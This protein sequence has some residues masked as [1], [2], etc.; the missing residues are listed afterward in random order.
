MTEPRFGLDDD[1]EW[2]SQQPSG[3]E[4]LSWGHLVAQA[5]FDGLSHAPVTGSRPESWSFAA[6]PGVQW[7]GSST[8]SEIAYVAL[9]RPV[10]VAIHA[11][12]LLPSP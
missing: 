1:G 12:D 7:G 6:S 2:Q 11:D 9:Q 5:D 3:W 8:S 10:R 4:D